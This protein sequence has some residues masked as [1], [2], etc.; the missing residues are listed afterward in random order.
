MILLSSLPCIGR[1]DTKES[2]QVNKIV[3]TQ[4]HILKEWEDQ[5]QVPNLSLAAEE[6]TIWMAT[7]K[8]ASILIIILCQSILLCLAVF[9]YNMCSLINVICVPAYIFHYYFDPVNN[10]CFKS[11]HTISSHTGFQLMPCFQN[12][13]LKCLSFPGKCLY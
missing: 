3:F 9:L 10:T 1:V 8:W 4:T 11:L 6:E 5:E 7:S 12:T 2:R 13:F